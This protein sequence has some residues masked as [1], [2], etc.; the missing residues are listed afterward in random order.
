MNLGV[1]LIVVGF[2]SDV[3]AKKKLGKNPD[4]DTSFL[5]DRDREVSQY[6]WHL[7]ETF[8]LYLRAGDSQLPEAFCFG[9]VRPSHSRE[10]DTS[11]MPRGN[12]FKLGTNINLDS[13]IDWLTD[14]KSRSWWL[15]KT[16]FWP[17]EYEGI[18]SALDQLSL[19]S[20]FQIKWSHLSGQ[21]SQWP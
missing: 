13:T 20:D 6:V 12:F 21:S 14:Q 10:H 1:Y 19:D 7:S 15:H 16:A 9:V 18:S 17:L 4:V 11:R 2:V 3:P 8:S 5:P